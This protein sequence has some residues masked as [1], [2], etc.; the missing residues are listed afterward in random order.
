[1]HCIILDSLSL[2]TMNSFSFL[3]CRTF[4]GRSHTAQWAP[5]QC[6]S[7]T[8][9]V[10]IILR[11]IWG[12]SMLLRSQTMLSD[13]KLFLKFLYTAA[14]VNW[15]SKSNICSPVLKGTGTLLLQQWVLQK[16]SRHKFPCV[17]L[18]TF[19]LDLLS[20]TSSTTS[21]QIFPP[22]ASVAPC[23]TASNDITYAGATSRTIATLATQQYQG[24]DFCSWSSSP[25]SG[26]N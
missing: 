7:S 6:H 26:M 10:C 11:R 22:Q 16:P 23:G 17:S 20:I 18:L 21:A 5:S 24:E 1:M 14:T 8:S 13:E 25:L 4:H 9:S 12:F 19:S 3:V 15:H 2:I